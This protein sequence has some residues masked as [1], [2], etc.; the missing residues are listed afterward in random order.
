MKSLQEI[1][2]DI[3]SKFF[4]STNIDV[5]RG[6]AIDYFMLASA[7][8]IEEA[9]KEIENNKTPH[10]F[11]SLSGSRIDDMGTLCG[12]SRKAN[13]SDKNFL[14]RLLNWNISNKAANTTAIEAALMD[15]KNCSHVT[16]VPHTFGCGTA[17]AYIIPKSMDEATR[18]LAIS[19]T[20]SVLAEVV[21]P[22]TYIE[23][24]IPDIRE[25][26]ITCLYKAT[27]MDKSAI[28]KNISNKIIE[29][30]NGIAP[31]ENLEIGHINKLG[32]TEP[33]IDYFNVANMSI[34]GEETGEVS[35]LQK[36]DSKLIIS[37]EN[38]I[39]LEVE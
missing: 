27:A 1:Y 31:G 17:T 23:Y 32:I 5:E 10:V 39:W 26:R 22:S 25:V 6:T 33:N 36:V 18:E 28:K 2:N 3:K 12:I 8:M 14:Y 16:Y 19:E 38:I 35:I 13:E 29:Y 11:S 4:N 7:N 20:K 37:V 34:N 9:H 24:I 15:L 30:V 21:S